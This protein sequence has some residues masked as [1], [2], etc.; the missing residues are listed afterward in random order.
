[1]RIIVDLLQGNWRYH[2]LIRIVVVIL[3]SAFYR[4]Y[5]ATTVQ[6]P[7]EIGV[8]NDLKQYIGLGFSRDDGFCIKCLTNRKNDGLFIWKD[9]IEK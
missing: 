8:F 6:S 3:T 1:M 4:A 9:E 7:F 2:R 5:P